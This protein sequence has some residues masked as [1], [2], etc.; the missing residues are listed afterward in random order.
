MD[1]VTAPVLV[2]AGENDPRCPF[3]Q[4]QNYVSALAA[5]R[6]DYRWYSFQA[7]HGSMVTEERLRQVAVSV[8]FVRDVL[9]RPRPA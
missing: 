4:V 7:G 1:R 5:R 6:A 9:G 2:T 3:G 8:A